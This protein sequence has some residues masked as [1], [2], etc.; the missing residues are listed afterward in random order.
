MS[1]CPSSRSVISLNALAEP[2]PE[3]VTRT[4]P[5]SC[6]TTDAIVTGDLPRLGRESKPER[7]QDDAGDGVHGAPD[8][9]HAQDVA[10]SHD[11]HEPDER[12]GGEEQAVRDERRERRAELR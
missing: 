6:S 5:S 9:R 12:Q 1:G 3:F 11:E 10:G 2:T 8:P 4:N 7:H